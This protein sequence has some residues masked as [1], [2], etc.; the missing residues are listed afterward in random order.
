MVCRVFKKKNQTR[1]FLPESIQEE[2]DE[3]Q[4][5]QHYLSHHIK[6]ISSSSMQ[7]K[8]SQIQSLYDHYSSF[9]GSMHL[10]QLFSPESAFMPPPSFPLNNMDIE[11]SQ[12]LLR[13]TSSNGCGSML[14]APTDH[15]FHGD[16]SFLDKLLASHQNNS[17]GNCS[18]STS[19]HQVVVD[20]NLVAPMPHKLPFPYLGC[21]NDL[22]MNFSK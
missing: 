18:S 1:S 14:Q 21:E 9:D 11:C 10:P 12:N 8:H 6:P 7:P 5:Q 15:R 3:Q 17:K 19:S 4:Q 22:T 16:W 20:H 13:L 2:L